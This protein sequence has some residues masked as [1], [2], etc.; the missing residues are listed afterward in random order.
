[1]LKPAY[2]ILLVFFCLYKTPSYA[3]PGITELHQANASIKSS[4]FSAFDASLVLATLLGI[5]GAVRIYHNLQMSKDRFT[6]DVTTWFLAALFIILIGP[7]L[8]KLFGI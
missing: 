5:C 1:M 7:F 6:T 4:F 3:Q 2:C 8:Q